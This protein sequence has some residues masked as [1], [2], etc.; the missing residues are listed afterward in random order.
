VT[1][2][3][4]SLVEADSFAMKGSFIPPGA[5]WLG[6]PASAAAAAAAPDDQERK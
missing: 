4:G 6:N 5:R 3:E 1:T 2:G